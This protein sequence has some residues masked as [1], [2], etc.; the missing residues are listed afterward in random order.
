LNNS[1]FAGGGQVGYNWQLGPYVVW[2][3]EADLDG[4]GAKTST[5][6]AFAGSPAL[7]P[8][9]TISSSQLD[10]LGALRARAGYLALLPRLAESSLIWHRRSCLRANQAWLG[11]G[12]PDVRAAMTRAKNSNGKPLFAD[13]DAITSQ[14]DEE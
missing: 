4:V 2:G 3:I 10:M 14:M 12:V 5:S 9:T 7:L 8:I 11:S 6:A 1:G 13:A